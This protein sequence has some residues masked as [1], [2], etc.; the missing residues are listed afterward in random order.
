MSDCRIEGTGRLGQAHDDSRDLQDVRFFR[1]RV[2]VGW[3]VECDYPK[4]VRHQGVKEALQA[5][6]RRLPT[7]HH[8]YCWAF[9][10]FID[11]DS[12][13]LQRKIVRSEVVDVTRSRSHGPKKTSVCDPTSDR[14][15][16]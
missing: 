8:Q 1:R 10:S 5:G 9:S 6:D 3:H 4:F 16:E 7:M 12:L 13:V 11:P 2:P 14:G 15:K